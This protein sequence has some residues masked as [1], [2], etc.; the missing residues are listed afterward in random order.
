M[1]EKNKPVELEDNELKYVAGG[2]IPDD[3]LNLKEDTIAAPVGDGGANGHDGPH[4]K[5]THKKPTG[6]PLI[7]FTPEN[8]PELHKP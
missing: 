8:V 4:R 2:V 3:I 7:P 5:P 1:S 6:M